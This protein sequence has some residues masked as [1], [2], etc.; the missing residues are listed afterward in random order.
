MAQTPTRPVT[1]NW[2][3]SRRKFMLGV[4]DLRA[5]RNFHPN[6][7]SWPDDQWS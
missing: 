5:G 1:L 4:E 3:M 2:I 7:E 6:Y